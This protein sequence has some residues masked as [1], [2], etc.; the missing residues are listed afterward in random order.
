MRAAGA[1][2]GAAMRDF[3][4]GSYYDRMFAAM[5]QVERVAEVAGT[6]VS[7]KS[8]ALDLIALGREFGIEIEPRTHAS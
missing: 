8:Y 5:V 6:R 4:A 1:L 3:F 7:Y 2:T